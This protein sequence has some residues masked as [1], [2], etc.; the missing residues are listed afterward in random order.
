MT[1]SLTDILTT[2]KNGV[3]A[4]NNL[5]QATIR[6]FGT[7]TSITVTAATLIYNGPGYLVS[8][9]IVVAGSGA[10]TINNASTIAG[11]AAA[12]A[13]CTT[14]FTVGV[15]KTGQIFSNGLVVIPGS[16]QSINVTYSPG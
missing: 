7:Q 12:N 13:L 5:A 16:G 9:S 14:P 15:F 1:A 11:A 10:G 8:F 4:I 3:V 6:G 2:Q